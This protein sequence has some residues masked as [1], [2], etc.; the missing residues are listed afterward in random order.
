MWF[1]E[2]ESMQ[3]QPSPG[4]IPAPDVHNGESEPGKPGH[5]Q[6][7]LPSRAARIRKGGAFGTART[8]GAAKGEGRTRL[9][10]EFQERT[11]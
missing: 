4:G 9:D 2:E 8:P 5:G 3:S 1:W 11:S 6:S 10:L 7:E